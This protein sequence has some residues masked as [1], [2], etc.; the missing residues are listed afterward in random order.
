MHLWLYDGLAAKDYEH[1]SFLLKWLVQY[2]S[3]EC[4]SDSVQRTFIGS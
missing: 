3:F 1:M 4:C 2:D